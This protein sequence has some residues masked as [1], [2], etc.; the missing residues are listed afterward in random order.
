MALTFAWCSY[1]HAS[2][3]QEN[4]EPETDIL[5]F[6]KRSFRLCAVRAIASASLIAIVH[7]KLLLPSI[8]IHFGRNQV[9]SFLTP[10]HHSI[11]GRF[12]CH[13]ADALSSLRV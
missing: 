8:R 9:E 5:P 11:S 2:G 13:G 6:W 12:R 3:G 10:F 1:L 4:T 7:L